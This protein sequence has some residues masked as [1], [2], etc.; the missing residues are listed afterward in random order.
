VSECVSTKE[1]HEGDNVAAYDLMRR[2]ILSD[3]R[4]GNDWEMISDDLRAQDD[5][6]EAQL[7]RIANMAIRELTSSHLLYIE[8]HLACI[9]VE[10]RIAKL[11]QFRFLIVIAL[12]FSCTHFPFNES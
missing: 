2:V 10:F 7:T 12:K 1:A 5:F 9:S 11:C 8:Y 6:K 3:P 4:V